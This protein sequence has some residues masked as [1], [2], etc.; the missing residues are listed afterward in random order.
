MMGKTTKA[1][2][3]E[4]LHTDGNLNRKEVHGLIDAFL[5]EI[6]GAMLAGNTVE[7]R[8][9]GTFGVKKRKGRQRGAEPKDWG[10][11]SRSGS[12][13]SSVPPRARTQERRM[14]SQAG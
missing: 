13:G 6:K 7:L 12:R 5:D 2:L 10:D 9:F 3:I 1:D 8:G 14:V 11:R 4:A